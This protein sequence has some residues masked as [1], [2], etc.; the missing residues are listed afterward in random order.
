MRILYFSRDYTTHDHRFLTALAASEHEVYYLRLEKRNPQITEQA[1]PSSVNIVN[2][3]G[4]NRPAKLIDGLKLL[5]QLRKIIQK[6]KPDILHAGPIQSVG[7]LAV[8]SGFRPVVTMSWAYD[9]LF[10]ANKN[11]FYRWATKKVLMESD[12]L[13]ADCE[14]IAQLAVDQGFLNNRI[15]KFPWGIDLELFSP[16]REKEIR[17]NLDWDKNHFVLLHTRS[18]EPIYGVDTFVEAFVQ[19]VKI[20]PELRLLLLGN[21]SMAPTIKKTLN[22]GNVRDKVHFAGQVMQ[23]DLPGY[24]RSADLY[25]SASH[26]DGSSVSLMEALGGGT[27][28]LLSDIPGNKEWISSGEQGWFFEDGNAEDLTKGIIQAIENKRDLKKMGLKARDVAEKRADWPKNF[29]KL[30]Q[31]YELAEGIYV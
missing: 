20:H 3:A 4:G 17:K 29:E 25:I 18:W 23:A 27:P 19:A 7:L 31:A 12:V 16:G 13:I 2:W 30:L 10:D 6:I 26:S 24:Y 21:G 11:M 5:R 14:H 1:L 28:V 22:Q 9:L 15:V 8:L